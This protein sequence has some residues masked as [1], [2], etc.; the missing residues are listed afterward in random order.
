[1]WQKVRE[2]QKSSAGLRFLFLKI[3]ENARRRRRT[4]EENSLSGA[5]VHKRTTSGFFIV[6][7]M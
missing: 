1:M 6:A 5:H 3:R 2:S 7:V 4:R